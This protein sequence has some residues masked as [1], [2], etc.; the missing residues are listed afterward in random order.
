MTMTDPTPTDTSA[1]AR[2]D[3]YV[4]AFQEEWRETGPYT[5]GFAR[6]VARRAA[7]SFNAA[8]VAT[9]PAPAP[10]D[11]EGRTDSEMRE[12]AI[13]VVQAE[14]RDMGYMDWDVAAFAEPDGDNLLAV[15]AVERVLYSAALRPASAPAATGE[16]DTCG[17]G[18]NLPE[19]AG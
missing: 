16:V 2:E 9:P 10:V 1:R 6:R 5:H 3:A 11:V 8:E 7:H 15:Q 13:A 4:S 19:K 17:N 14:A 12:H 18:R